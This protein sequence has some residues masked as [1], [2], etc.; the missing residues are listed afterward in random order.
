[1]S[2]TQPGIPKRTAIQ[3]NGSAGAYI[4][5]KATQFSRYFE[6]QE[7]PPAD[8]TFNGTNFNP[9]GLTYQLPQDSPAYSTTY[10]LN[11][12][13]ILSGGDRSWQRD[14]GK[15]VPSLTYPDGSTV[16]ATPYANL[17]SATATGTWVML[18][19]WN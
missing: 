16:A 15:G 12:G 11:P 9:Q 8:G 17:K 19:E 18:S 10:G 5:A 4:L 7:C 6:I 2:E 3:I 14:F 13:D 1:M